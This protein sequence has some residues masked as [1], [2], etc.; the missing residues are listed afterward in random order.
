MTSTADKIKA[1]AVKYGDTPTAL[2]LWQILRDL[3][4]CRDPEVVEFYEKRRFRK[5]QMAER[6]E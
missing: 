1:A 2:R 6:M 5:A 3:T 4:D